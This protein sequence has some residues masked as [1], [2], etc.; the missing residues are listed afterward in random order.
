VLSLAAE[1][2]IRDL[3]VSPIE[4]YIVYPNVHRTDPWTFFAV[5]DV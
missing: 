5:R 3:G 1:D 2:T 4:E